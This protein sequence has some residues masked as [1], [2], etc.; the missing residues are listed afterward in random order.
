MKFSIPANTLNEAAVFAAK[1]IS[2]N[3]L[4]P[5]LGGLHIE[6]QADGV[7]LTG[8]SMEQTAKAHV[9]ADVDAT[10]V[11]VLPAVMLTSVLAKLRNRMCLV[12]LDGT[13][14]RL[15]AGAANFTLH[16][17]PAATYPQ[18]AVAP[19]VVGSVDGEALAHAVSMVAGAASLDSTPQL[20]MLTG[21]NVVFAGA[22]VTLLATDR[23]RLAMATLPWAPAAGH[24]F[25]VLV[26][27]SWLH[28]LT[29]TMVGSVKVQ[30]DGN[31][32]GLDTGQRSSVSNIIDGDYPKIQ[33]LFPK[34]CHAE[35]TVERAVFAEAIDRVATVA[36][37]N[38][39]IRLRFEDG[40]VTLDAGTGE[41]SQGEE[42]IECD[43]DGAPATVSF[44]PGYLGWSVS[45]MMTENIMIRFQD[46]MAKPALILPTVGETKHLV[47]PIRL[48]QAA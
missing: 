3:P 31:Q 21:I 12:E 30:H 45:T 41:D 29:K 23:Y 4:Q 36:E 1:A 16:C 11:A 10:G 22:E 43:Y 5:I 48:P 33:S 28:P 26:K 18:L 17:M 7:H 13:L 14:V 37:R 25:T 2:K 15:S 44:N 24:D 38:T 46:N 42:T 32:F 19:A 39:P 27:G 20:A 34:L 9:D 8:S 35:A 40:S 47:M 6:A